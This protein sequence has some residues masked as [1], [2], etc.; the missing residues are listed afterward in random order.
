MWL[1]VSRRVVIW[2]NAAG[3]LLFLAALL[4]IVPLETPGFG[5]LFLL[6]V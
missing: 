5:L 2:L 6:F 1:T 3:F 4:G